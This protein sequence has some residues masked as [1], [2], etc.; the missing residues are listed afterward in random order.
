MILSIC[1]SLGGQSY[2]VLKVT[3][4]IVDFIQ[5]GSFGNNLSTP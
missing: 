2:L 3:V 4:G 5:Q 1:A